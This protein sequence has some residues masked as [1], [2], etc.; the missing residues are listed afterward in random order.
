MTR[1]SRCRA[2]LVF[3]RF[4]GS[5]FWNYR[6]TCEL[7]GARY[8]AAPLGLVTLAAL[9]PAEWE[10]RL[11][12]RNVEELTDAD[13]GWAD[14]VMTGGMLPQRNDALHVVGRAQPC[15]KPVVVGGPD[16]T[17][18]PEVYARAEFRVLGEAEEILAEF[19][20]AWRDGAAGGLFV[21]PR[22][23]DLAR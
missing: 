6:K 17:C 14:V 12:D 18:A 5:S 8:S 22:F 19:L 2:L 4:A 13:L 15:G 3:P 7:L 10:L 16:A 20:A 9:L 21:A 1:S 23:P 11:V